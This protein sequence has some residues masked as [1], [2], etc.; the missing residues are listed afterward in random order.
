MAHCTECRNLRSF[1]FLCHRWRQQNHRGKAKCL[2]WF[3][4]ATAW[5]IFGFITHVL[6]QR[7]C[8]SLFP[9]LC[10]TGCLLFFYYYFYKLLTW[11]FSPPP[12]SCTSSLS[13][14]SSLFPCV[15]PP[16]KDERALAQIFIK[17]PRMH[18]PWVCVTV[19]RERKIQCLCYLVPVYFW[20]PAPPNPPFFFL[21][22]AESKI[23]L[24]YFIQSPFPLS[25]GRLCGSLHVVH[26]FSHLS[27]LVN[28]SF[29]RCRH[30]PSHLATTTH[31][32]HSLSF[33]QKSYITLPGNLSRAYFLFSL[34]MR[35][36]LCRDVRDGH[37][38]A[39][40]KG[41]SKGKSR[42]FVWSWRHANSVVVIARA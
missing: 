6:S 2:T 29:Y 22:V 7:K 37:F 41:R 39:E 10:D 32:S 9:Y 33:L 40:R 35:K 26:F 5:P 28:F 11:Y 23:F 19:N 31:R 4:C 20:Q 15:C 13:H 38:L 25:F 8:F 1:L 42:H 12:L 17:K 36:D 30:S 16:S 3:A 21:D 18:A 34:N 27:F 24:Y 14:T